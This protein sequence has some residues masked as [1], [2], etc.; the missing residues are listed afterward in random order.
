MNKRTQ[1][2]EMVAA[3]NLI[4][5]IEEARS[6]KIK[7]LTD[8]ERRA[9]ITCRAAYLCLRA[10]HKEFGTTTIE[11]YKSIMHVL[12]SLLCEVGINEYEPN[13]AMSAFNEG[14]AAILAN[15][16]D[17]L[18][19]IKDIAHVGSEDFHPEY[20]F[21]LDTDKSIMNLVEARLSGKGVFVNAYDVVHLLEYIDTLE[22]KLEK[23][24]S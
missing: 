3:I 4:E 16:I 9:G 13:Q 7:G 22:D 19:T 24:K 23:S 8:D 2:D 6:H 10:A 14:H 17:L 21:K 11:T 1:E 5:I 20:E 18:Q 15:R 12:V